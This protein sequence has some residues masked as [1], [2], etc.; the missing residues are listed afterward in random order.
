MKHAG[1]DAL[2]Q[3]EPILIELRKLSALRE[4]KRG[5][6]Y[7]KSAGFLHFHED[8][9]GMFADLKIDGDFIRLPVNTQKEADTLIRRAGAEVKAVAKRT[10]S[11]AGASVARRRAESPRAR[12]D[13]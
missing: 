5:A 9:A 13:A 1:S 11:A 10:T 3:L 6:F 2:D 4:R 7:L 12:R 8:P